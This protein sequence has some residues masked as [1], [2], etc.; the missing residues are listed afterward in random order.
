[1]TSLNERRRHEGVE[2]EWWKVADVADMVK[3][4]FKLIN[5]GRGLSVRD[6]PPS[7]GIMKLAVEQFPY[8]KIGRRGEVQL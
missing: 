7:S 6:F 3:E 4:E 8:R 2:P 1:M 5:D